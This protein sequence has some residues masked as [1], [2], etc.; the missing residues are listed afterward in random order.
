VSNR[1]RRLCLVGKAFSLLFGENLCSRGG[2]K[3]PRRKGGERVPV[4][5]QTVSEPGKKKRPLLGEAKKAFPDCEK[6][7]GGGPSEKSRA[8]WAASKSAG[9]GKREKEKNRD[10]PKKEH[11]IDHQEKR[12]AA[13]GGSGQKTKRP[14]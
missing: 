2:K 12:E 14:D 9:R 3:R 8:S 6:G 1:E 5:G 4:Q 13:E 7:G 11:L 10:R